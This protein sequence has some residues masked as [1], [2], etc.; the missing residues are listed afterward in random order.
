MAKMLDNLEELKERRGE[1]YKR[2]VQS[3][4]VYN[5]SGKPMG[6]A[7]NRSLGSAFFLGGVGALVS[8]MLGVL[9]CRNCKHILVAHYLS[10][11]EN[12]EKLHDLFEQTGYNSACDVATYLLGDES[13]A[14]V[15]FE[16]CGAREYLMSTSLGITA[17]S[18][19]TAGVCL[20]IPFVYKYSKDRH[21]KNYK[22]NYIASRE[23]YHELNEQCEDLEIQIQTIICNGW[24]EFQASQNGKNSADTKIG[25]TM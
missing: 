3:K 8:G 4:E 15:M 9:A 24:N 14:R 13:V 2:Y 1:A 6:F 12:A 20:T 23:N 11:P 19:I 10:K 21:K 18:V 17:M 25:K 5:K 22:N 7:E 16:N